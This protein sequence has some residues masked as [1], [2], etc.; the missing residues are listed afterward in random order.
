M[1]AFPVSALILLALAGLPAT[2]LAAP[3]CP[4]PHPM[5]FQVTGR[6]QAGIEGFTE[7]LEVHDGD[8]YESTGAMDGTTRLLR[9]TP[10]GHAAVLAD[11]GDRFFGEG[12]T[13][14]DGRLYQ[15]SW[16]DHKVFVYDRHWRLLRTMVN[17][18]EGWGLTNDG[19][20]LI[21]GDGSD[22]LYFA[23]PADFRTLATVKVRRG[24]QPVS[25]INELEYVGGKI[26]A[27]IWQ[28]RAIVR[29]DPRTGCIEAEARLDT[30]WD[31]MS[32]AERNY[33]GVDP[34]FVLNG[35]AYDPARRLFYLTGKEWPMIFTGRFQ[36]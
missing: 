28:T 11:F 17:P 23:D 13:F 20:R 33:T 4:A 35:I 12:L 21:Y 15:L 25:N 2:G 3:A 5:H 19:R 16:R 22:T 14:L 7:G 30:L 1:R 6:F 34:D 36:G 26:Y 31:H 8:L 32:Q 9:I 24:G 29:I 10:K 27:N 18:H